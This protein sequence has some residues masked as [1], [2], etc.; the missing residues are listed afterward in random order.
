MTTTTK[1]NPQELLSQLANSNSSGCLELDEGLVSWKIYLQQGK[2]KYIYCS[3]QLLD[4]L[5]YYLRYLGLKQALNGLKELPSSD[6]KLESYVPEKSSNKNFYSKVICWLLTE[7]YLEPSQGLKLIEQI[8]K[9]GLSSCLWLDKGTSSWHDGYSLPLWIK[10]KFGDT[11]SLDISECLQVEQTRLKQWQQNCSNQLLSVHQRPYFAPAW[12]E[13]SLPT[14]GLLN[15]KTL[16]ELTQVIRGRTSIRQLSLLLNKDELQVAKILSPYIDAEII[17]LR[18]ARTPLDLLP[19]VPRFKKNVRQPLSFSSSTNSKNANG[20]LENSTFKTWKI[21]CI[22]DSP[23]ILKEIQRFLD[24]KKFEVTAID[25]PVK[26]T[27]IIFRINPDLILLDI[28]MPRINGYRLCGLLRDSYH[29]AHTPIIMVTGNTGLIDKTR[30][31]LVGATDYF[32]KP[33]T[34]EGLNKIVTK[35]LN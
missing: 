16:K 3:A 35:H 14:S 28:T 11:P 26:A 4:Q 34:Q 15:H 6:D 17:Q 10:V 32:T 1:L 22:D 25:D 30:A 20:N 5:K 2:L 33:F 13:Q 18:D 19:T 12:E 9:D 21:V 7:K 27:S 23:T 29:C 24:P 8:T 31:K